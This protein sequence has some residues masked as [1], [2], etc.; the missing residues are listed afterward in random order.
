MKKD[1][2]SPTWPSRQRLSCR[3]IVSRAQFDDM[4][5]LQIIAFVEVCKVPRRLAENDAYWLGQ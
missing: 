3:I 2:K 5:A 4:S 1:G